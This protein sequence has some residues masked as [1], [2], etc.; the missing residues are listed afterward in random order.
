MKRDGSMPADMS[1]VI[2]SLNGAAG[3]DRCLRALARQSIRSHLEIIVVDDGSSDATADVARAHGVT[4][5]SHPHNRGI[6]A[7]RN[8]G[9]N[10]TS[11][12]IVA[13]LDDDC[14]PEPD[15]A[16]QMLNGY[17]D[18]NV[19]AVAGEI[20]PNTPPGYM[21]GYLARNNPLKPLEHELAE[22]HGLP[23]RFRLYLR[24]LWS[25]Q[26][27]TGRRDV[28]AFGCA[29]T[30]F[31]RKALFDAGQF[32]ERFSFGGE[33]LDMCWRV[34]EAIASARL[35]FLP[36]ARAE[37]HFKPDLRDTLRR[38]RAY[39][40][41]SGRLY[42][43]WPSVLPALF[44]GPLLVLLML[45]AA[46]WLPA[47]AIAAVLAPLVLYPIGLRA[48]VADRD[49]AALFDGYVKLAQETM[50]SVGFIQGYWRYRRLA[51]YTP[52]GLSERLSQ[53]Q[54]L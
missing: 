27:K 3:V 47:F 9:L 37:H 2:C 29:N 34:R 45:V 19:V 49:P 32:D 38:S 6:A 22:N 17:D 35:I 24:R 5:I 13:Y 33:D 7:A 44:P 16:V 18:E 23:Y 15:W 12:D 8:T 40:I 11:A 10:A 26:P 41:G 1:V 42:R 20:V 4:V 28:Y 51:P 25:A 52:T 48:A 43:K 31:R 30:S 53:E 46:P 14:E 54:P 36:E 21:R 50:E 39:G